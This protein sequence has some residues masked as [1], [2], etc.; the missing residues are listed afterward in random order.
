MIIIE[1]DVLHNSWTKFIRKHIECVVLESPASLAIT[2]SQTSTSIDFLRGWW[3]PFFHPFFTPWVPCF[4]LCI[5]HTNASFIVRQMHFF[6]PVLS[7]VSHPKVCEVLSASRTSSYTLMHE[8][9]EHHLWSNHTSTSVIFSCS[10]CLLEVV[11]GMSWNHTRSSDCM[12]HSILVSQPIHSALTVPCWHLSCTKR[13]IGRQDWVSL[14]LKKSMASQGVLRDFSTADLE[15]RLF[16]SICSGS[17]AYLP[18][19]MCLLVIL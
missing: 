2:E 5:T 19:S 12:S 9:L 8:N 13:Y 15:W 17:L 10:H 1:E 11:M 3:H 18:A 16:L 6:S 4:D 7:I 14:I